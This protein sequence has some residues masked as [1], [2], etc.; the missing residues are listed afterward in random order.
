[1]D[2]TQVHKSDTAVGAATAAPDLVR[3]IALTKQYDGRVAL[4]HA[5]FSI[6]AGEILGII[7]PNGAGKTTLLESICALL[8]IDSGKIFWDDRPLLPARR[9]QF[10]FY[11]PDGIRPYQDQPVVHVLS[12]FSEIY[13]M[14]RSRVAETVEALGLAP[15]LAN[16][17]GALSKGYARR[18]LLAI[19]LLTP[20]PL[21]LMDEPFDGFDLRQTRQ[22][23]RLLRK[24]TEQGRTLVLAIHQLR[25]AESVCDRFLLLIEGRVRGIGTIDELRARTALPTANLEELF[26]ALT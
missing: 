3:S 24:V 4:D 26:L 14:P 19:G 2:G 23:I 15:V 17:V 8:P 11:L 5:T 22:I 1:M 12:L 9:R 16:R 7:G 13:R 18:L 10:I 21:L 20:H 6:R 25:D